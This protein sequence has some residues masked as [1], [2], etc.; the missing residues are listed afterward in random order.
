MKWSEKGAELTISGDTTRKFKLEKLAEAERLRIVLEAEADAD[1]ALVYSHAGYAGFGYAG[2]HPYAYGAFPYYAGVKSAPCVNAANIPVPCAGVHAVHKREAEADADAAVLY[3]HAGYAGFGYAGYPYAYGAFPYAYGH[4][5]KS[6]PCVNAAN[7]PVPCAAGHYLGKREAEADADAAV[8]YTH[9]GYAG[10]GYPYTYGAYPYAYGT[11][12]AP[13][14]AAAVVPTVG[15]AATNNVLGH[16]VAHTAFG[17]THSS[18]V[19][20]CTNYLGEQVAC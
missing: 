3:S 19:G 13:A 2:Y 20:V 1:A 9:A 18:N 11:Y 15:V 17:V 16:A 4:G 6:A 8:L 12:A 5:L 7:V 10:F 14:V